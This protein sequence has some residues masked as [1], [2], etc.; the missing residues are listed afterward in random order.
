MSKNEKANTCIITELNTPIV[1]MNAEKLD[2]ETINSD[3]K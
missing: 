2:F 1:S 3:H